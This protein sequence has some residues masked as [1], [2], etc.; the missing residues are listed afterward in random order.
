MAGDDEIEASPLVGNLI[1]VKIV[2]PL[3]VARARI[4]HDGL[5][6]CLVFETLVG[7]Y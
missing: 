1:G 5:A 2:G 6:G 7:Q 4:G 3:R